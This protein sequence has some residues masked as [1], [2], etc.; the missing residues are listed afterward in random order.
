MVGVRDLL[1]KFSSGGAARGGTTTP[2]VCKLL[3]VDG[4][5]V[6][7]KDVFS[8]MWNFPS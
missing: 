5:P 1:S 4:P 3:G 7:M 2:G 8:E 6:D